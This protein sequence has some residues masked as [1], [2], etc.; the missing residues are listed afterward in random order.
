MKSPLH[1]SGRKAYRKPNG[2]PVITSTH[3]RLSRTT[4]LISS[5][6][7]LARVLAFG[8]FKVYQLYR[9][10]IVLTVPFSFSLK[11]LEDSSHNE[12]PWISKQ[13][14][15]S[16]LQLKSTMWKV[17]PATFIYNHILIIHKVSYN[18]GVHGPFFFI[19]VGVILCRLI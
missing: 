17:I 4:H 16:C 7:I 6:F 14:P 3:L 15:L 18:K 19:C 10:K 2:S 1:Q 8:S 9:H 5:L 13:E 11:H 12:K